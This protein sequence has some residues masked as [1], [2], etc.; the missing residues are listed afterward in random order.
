MQS[1]NNFT[2]TPKFFFGHKGDVKGN[3]FW[4]DNSTVC[5]PCGHNIIFYNTDDKT[6]KFIPGIEGSE[7]IT[8][9]ALSHNRK[10]LAV[11]EQSTK[12]ICSVYNVGKM[13]ETFKEK[14]SASSV[15]DQVTIKKRRVLL[16]S[17]YAAT[18]FISVDF[19][20]MNEKLLVT[21]GDDGR[22]VVWQY[23]KQKALASD[24]MTLTSPLS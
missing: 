23:D 6:Q 10:S 22:I 19:C 5:Y 17:D 16:S 7:G 21:L 11:C 1:G 12:A 3:L 15:I 8:A 2:M 13:L 4:L 24:V 20:Q 14:K 18:K 9:M